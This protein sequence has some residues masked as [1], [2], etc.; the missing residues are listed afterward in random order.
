VEEV[1]SECGGLRLEPDCVYMATVFSEFVQTAVLI[2]RGISLKPQF[3]YDAVSVTL[4]S[5]FGFN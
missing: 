3:N 1:R 2:S 4:I 5:R